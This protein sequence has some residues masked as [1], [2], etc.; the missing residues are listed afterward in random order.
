MKFLLASLLLLV[1]IA[2]SA[3]Y[4]SANFEFNHETASAEETPITSSKIFLSTHTVN[5][6]NRQINVEQSAAYSYLFLSSHFK[7]QGRNKLATQF[8]AWSDEETQHANELADYLIL[9]RGNLVYHKINEP[10][11]LEAQLTVNG[12][13]KFVL[14]KEVEVYESIL[15]VHNMSNDPSM[16]DFLVPFLNEGIESVRKAHDLVQEYNRMQEDLA[17]HVFEQTFFG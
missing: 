5:L 11:F 1:K 3:N 8:K 14:D 4:D 15:N 16:E 7:N 12:A 13:L 9:R 2:T 6:L 10:R 17:T